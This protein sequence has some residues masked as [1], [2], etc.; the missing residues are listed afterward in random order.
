MTI[1]NHLAQENERFFYSVAVF[2]MI[3]LLFDSMI[4]IMIVF[5]A[6]ITVVKLI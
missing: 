3:F 4:G 6:K 1:N 5:I 2:G